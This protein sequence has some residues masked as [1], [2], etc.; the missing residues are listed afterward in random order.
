[1]PGRYTLS[2]RISSAGSGRDGGYAGQ[3]NRMHL[4][5]ALGYTVW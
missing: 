3:L 4:Q 2:R 1:M 5:I